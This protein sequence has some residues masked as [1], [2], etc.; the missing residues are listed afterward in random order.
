MR[1]SSLSNDKVVDLLNHFFVPVY[2]SN[3]DFRKGGCAPEEERKELQ[4]IF[5]ETLDAKRSAGTVHVY[6]LGPDGK[7][8]DSMHVAYAAKVEKLIPMLEAAVAQYKLPAAQTLFPPGPQSRHPKCSPDALVLHLVARN[9]TKQGDDIVA[10]KTKLG[11]TRSAGWGSYPSEDW[12]IF[13]KDESAK[14]LPRGDVQAGTT[15]NL[16][17]DLASRFLTHFYPTTENNDVEKNKIQKQQ[18][19]GKIVS[20]KDGVVR[21]QLSGHLTMEHWFYHKA[22]GNVVDTRLAGYLDFEPA[23]G[24]IRTF[25]LISEDATYSRR[26]FGVALRSLD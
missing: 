19:S 18:L 4:R 5:R 25:R 17:A 14:L 12:I 11:E 9:V 13:S 20:V 3:E 2:L 6:L 22:D 7:G 10:T 16:E 21:A 15:W 24:R 8:L 26:P 23:T 1:A